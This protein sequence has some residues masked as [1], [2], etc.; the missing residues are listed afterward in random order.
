[1]NYLVVDSICL[2]LF[3][4][5]YIAERGRY[6]QNNYRLVHLIQNFQK[7]CKICI[8]S[9]YYFSGKGW[10]SGVVS[11]L[12][13]LKAFV[14]KICRYENM[15]FIS[16]MCWWWKPRPMLYVMIVTTLPNESGLVH[17]KRDQS[18]TWFLSFRSVMIEGHTRLLSFPFRQRDHDVNP[19]NAK[20]EFVIFIL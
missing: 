5:S 19:L 9:Y 6:Q 20:P 17:K 13:H 15:F 14:I 4:S 18:W 7:K 11:Y 2:Y 12:S 16:G 10:H 1:M 3:I 8:F